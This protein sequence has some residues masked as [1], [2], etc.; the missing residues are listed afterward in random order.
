MRG[1]TVRPLAPLDPEER[2]PREEMLAGDRGGLQFQR[3][4]AGWRKLTRA[5]LAATIAA[6]ALILLGIALGESGAPAPVTVISIALLVLALA[7][8]ALSGRSRSF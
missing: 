1:S 3:Q 4:P 5:E 7:A 8:F 2:R 6:P